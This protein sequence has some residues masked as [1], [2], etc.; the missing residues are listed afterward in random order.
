MAGEPR[1]PAGEPVDV[2]GHVHP[3]SAPWV[4]TTP[5]WTVRKISVSQMDN[6]VYLLTCAV[7]GA[8]AL[9]DAADDA[10]AIET[11]IASGTGTLDLL[12]TTH[13]HWDHVRALAAVTGRHTP[14][15]A[16]GAADAD[17]LPVPVDRPLEDGDSLRVGDLRLDVVALRGHTPGSIA[18]GLTSPDG[19]RA[20]FTGDSLFPG[21]PGRTTSTGDFTSLMVDLERRV[22]G[23]EDDETV[24]LPG[25]G[26]NTT[27]G[28]ER[29]HLRQWRERGW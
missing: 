2:A 18:V 14:V 11:L 6:D 26:D 16:A 5:A 20:L 27:I 8:Q 12:V 28:R 22:F 15:T 23:R 13:R 24:V 7:T 19:Q 21:G 3:G 10:G 4:W 9:I 25:H 29:P 17:A 1:D